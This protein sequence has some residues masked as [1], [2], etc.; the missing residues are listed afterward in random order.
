ML[1]TLHDSWRQAHTHTHT[2]RFGSVCILYLQVRVGWRAAPLGSVMNAAWSYRRAPRAT[3]WVTGAAALP[4]RAR[5]A[6]CRSRSGASTGTAPCRWR[7]AWSCSSSPLPCRCSRAGLVS[8]ESGWMR[9]VGSRC[10]RTTGSLARAATR[11]RGYW[12]RGWVA[13]PPRS[14]A[15]KADSG[16]LARPARSART[17]ASWDWSACK[18]PTETRKRP[19]SSTCRLGPPRS[20]S[21]ARRAW[22]PGPGPRTAARRLDSPGGRRLYRSA[23]A[24]CL[25]ADSPLRPEVTSSTRPCARRERSS[26]RTASP[27]YWTL[28][29]WLWTSCARP[30]PSRN[31]VVARGVWKTDTRWV[32]LQERTETSE[33]FNQRIKQQVKC[34]HGVRSSGYI[35]TF[36]KTLIGLFQ[37]IWGKNAKI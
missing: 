31:R 6:R 11:R 10:C 5:T 1:G 26:A 8:S 9:R 24:A 15:G 37:N 19:A 35:A 22:R 34:S 4:R 28:H 7:S 2:A 14:A 30:G 33:Q 27:G 20:R 25:R 18:L 36:S 3:R 12:P 13:A 23:A 17:P 16:S 21:Y 29:A 32:S